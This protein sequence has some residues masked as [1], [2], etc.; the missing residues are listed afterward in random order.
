MFT[1]AFMQMVYIIH[2]RNNANSQCLDEGGTVNGESLN[3]C[4]L[5]DSFKIV[6]L[7]VIGEGFIVA[8]ASSGDATIVLLLVF[9]V[10]AFI[11]IL[12]TVSLTILNLQASGV[13]DTMVESFWSPMLTH[14][15]LIHQLNDIFCF[16]GNGRKPCFSLNSRLEDMWDYMI[17]SYSDV[18][19]RDTKWWYLQRDLGQSHLLGK[20]WFVRMVGFFVIPI[21]FCIGLATLG[22]LWPP[23]IRQWIFQVGM[24]EEDLIAFDEAVGQS[25]FSQMTLL[26]SDVSNM[27][28][29]M[30]DRFQSVEDELYELRSTIERI[31]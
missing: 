13:K 20:K 2:T 7:L 30:Y 15:L 19:I 14:V 12:H 25:D 17:V 8:E 27:K 21:W 6:Y 28:M 4:S 18:D 3:I 11:L 26:Q 16:G 31:R 10:L 1:L 29:M 22:I 5:W 9:V 24:D 23:Q